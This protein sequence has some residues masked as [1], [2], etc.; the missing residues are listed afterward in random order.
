MTK[1]SIDEILNNHKNKLQEQTGLETEDK[2]TFKE[3]FISS[4]S[5]E[6]ENGSRNILYTEA[7][8]LNE[9]NKKIIEDIKRKSAET[10]NL[11]FIPEDKSNYLSSKSA[12]LNIIRELKIVHDKFNIPRY[13]LTLSKI[14]SSSNILDCKLYATIQIRFLVECLNKYLELNNITK[15][16]TLDVGEMLQG[17]ERVFPEIKFKFLSEITLVENKLFS[18]GNIAK[19]S[20]SLVTDTFY[21]FCIARTIGFEEVT[22]KL[23]RASKSFNVGTIELLLQEAKNTLVNRYGEETYKVFICLLSYWY[24]NKS[25]FNSAISVSGEEVLKHLGKLYSKNNEGKRLPK[26]Y[27]LQWL[28]HQCE[29]IDGLKVYSTGIKPNQKGKKDFMID[30]TYLIEFPRIKYVAKQNEKVKPDLSNIVNLHMTYKAGEWFDYFNSNDHYQQFGFY[31]KKALSEGILGNFLSWI[32]FSTKQNQKGIFKVKTVLEAI[33]KREKLSSKLDSKSKTRLF[34][35]FNSM[36]AEAQSIEDLPQIITY[37]PPQYETRKP[38]G[39]FESWLNKTITIKDK[40]Q[41]LKAIEAEKTIDVEKSNKL[42]PSRLTVEDLKSAL[43]EYKDNRNVSLRKISE[44]CNIPRQTVS[45]KIKKGTLTQVEL[46]NLI[47]A[48]HFLG[49]NKNHLHKPE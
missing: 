28:A 34:D 43:D 36:I 42:K 27:N 35:D 17:I 33:G 19:T 48:C 12:M 39:W 32:A 21:S 38:K 24:E 30:R 20:T 7:I 5:G 11:D 22:E 44:C 15:I 4:M 25:S 3:V 9:E 49:M 47:N 6:M 29:L 13:N 23:H 41:T 26:K 16:T 45:R 37:D 10:Y 2:S 14:T 1:K 18:D 31:H 8:F 46:K 40:H